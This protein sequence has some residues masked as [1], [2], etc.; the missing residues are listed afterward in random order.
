MMRRSFAC[1]FKDE[2]EP[3]K[4]LV[5][6]SRKTPPPFVIG[7]LFTRPFVSSKNS[8]PCRQTDYSRTKVPT[9]KKANHSSR[10]WNPLCWP[11]C[12]PVAV[13]HFALMPSPRMGPGGS[14]GPATSK[15]YHQ[16][17]YP[18]HMLPFRP[19]CSWLAR[20]RLCDFFCT[21]PLTEL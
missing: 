12:M 8:L 9:R 11:A 1:V 14:S 2:R 16:S 5:C 4:S 10:G 7:F 21:F 13:S 17:S 20:A 18:R 19:S 3:V 15:T 6:N